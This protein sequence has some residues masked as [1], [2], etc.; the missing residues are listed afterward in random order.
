MLYERVCE[1]V[2]DGSEKECKGGK[3]GGRHVPHKD[4]NERMHLMHS[5]VVALTFVSYL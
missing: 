5:P 3:T 4:K 1:A 2:G